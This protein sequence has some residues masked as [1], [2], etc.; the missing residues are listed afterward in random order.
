MNDQTRRRFDRVRGRDWLS[1]GYSARQVAEPA[2]PPLTNDIHSVFS[3][4]LDELPHDSATKARWGTLT[5]EEYGRLD[6]PLRLA[7]QLLESAPSS[8]AICSL[9]YGDRRVLAEKTSGKD[10]PAFE[11]R[12]HTLEPS[13]VR[14]E[15]GDILKKLGKSIRFALADRDFS[16]ES[17]NIF[18]QGILARA[19]STSVNCPQGIAITDGPERR[20]FASA[21]VIS[22]E[23]LKT[24]DELHRDLLD[25]RYQVRKLNIELAITICHEVIHSINYALELDQLVT[26]GRMSQRREQ[27]H[28]NEPFYK[29]Q[30]VAELGFFWENHV[31]GGIVHQSKPDD[32]LY[33]CEW[34][35]W[36]YRFKGEQP[37]RGLPKAKAYKWLIATYYVQNTQSQDFWDQ[38]NLQHP[39]D[40]LA[41]RIRKRV[42]FKC[43]A[44]ANEECDETWYPSDDEDLLPGEPRIP[45]AQKDPSP[46]AALA[47]E[48][49]HEREV[50][51]NRQRL[52]LSP[53]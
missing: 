1:H 53:G 37:E 47:N 50:R 46:G 12:K 30:F 3:Y 8:D 21:V 42:A 23:Y 15:A 51:L 45:W 10:I 24:L 19:T 28:F 39:H 11:F 22:P 4:E 20:G 6:Q 31:F 44:P 32:P 5:L 13:T 29:G 52:L 16:D 2:G 34:P 43:W 33:L 18:K 36:L 9:V 40:L 17:K 41:L 49:S 38:V 14:E 7:T 35:S 26:Y 27:P 25:K 48:T